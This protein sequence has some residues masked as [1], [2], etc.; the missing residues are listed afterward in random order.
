MAE[1]RLSKLTKQFS[2]DKLLVQI[3]KFS[4]K[5]YNRLLI[6]VNLFLKILDFLLSCIQ[7]NLN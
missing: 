3:I 4:L 5:S 2:I 6:L 1:I 7:L